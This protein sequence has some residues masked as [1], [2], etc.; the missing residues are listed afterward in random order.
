MKTIALAGNPNCGKS[1]LFNL[2]TG[3]DAAVGNWPGV[4][5]ERKEAF[6][7]GAEGLRWIDL[8]GVYALS[9]F[10]PEEQVTRRFLLEETPDAIVNLADA[11][12]PERSLYLTLQL[13]ELDIPVLLVWNMEDIAAKQG[14]SIDKPA[15]SRL[16]GIPVLGV[17]ALTGEGTK[18]LLQAAG[19]AMRESRTGRIA[20]SREALPQCLRERAA[21]L[22]RQG[23]RHSLFRAADALENDAENGTYASLFAEGRYSFIDACTRKAIHSPAGQT[24]PPALDRLFLSPVWGIPLFFLLMLLVFHVT[25]GASLFG[26]GVPSPGVFLHRSAERGLEMLSALLF[27]RMEPCF[28]RDFLSEGIF[29]GIG[30]ALS[31]LPQI[32]CLFFCM[33]LLEDS[34]CMA[35]AAFLLDAPLRRLGLTG[36]ALLPA[37]TGFGCSVPAFLSVRTLETERSRK[38]ARFLI[39]FFSCGAKLPLYALLSAAFFPRRA[40]QVIA[41]LYAS[42]VLAAVCAGL[43]LHKITGEKDSQPFV[44]EIP[45]YRLP[46]WRNLRRSLGRHCGD[47]LNKAATVILAASAA[48]WL[49][50]R[51]TPD[52]MPADGHDSVLEYGGKLLAPF[53]TPLGFGSDGEGWKAAAALLSGLLA[54]EAAVSALGTLG[55]VEGLFTPASA[56]SFLVFYLLYPPCTAALSVYWSEEP[57]R[58]WRLCAPAAWLLTAWG[59]AFAVYL[60]AAKF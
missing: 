9:P 17:S 7:G 39:P 51:I 41:G 32:L 54:K 43:F 27:S 47:Y 58:T 50:S 22:E 56:L 4:T 23:E 20:W 15:L 28:F 24:A 36:R 44:M 57:S 53:F 49:L 29:G 33:E 11:S 18:E 13:L 31:F 55:G 38:I 60:I 8:P 35:R 21:E 40:D 37:L 19:K 16:L 2:L 1:A 34:G 46:R 45:A 25:F 6:S 48:V 59:I 10:T 3:S 52:F 12:T 26:S 5:V 42:G 30:T 14:I